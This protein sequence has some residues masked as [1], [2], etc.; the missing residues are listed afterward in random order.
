MSSKEDQTS[1]WNKPDGTLPYALYNPAP[2][3]AGKLTWMVSKDEQGRVTS[4]YRFEEI[5]NGKVVDVKREVGYLKD[6]EEAKHF[7]TELKAAGWLPLKAPTINFI[8]P[9]ETEPRDLNRKERRAVVK[10]FSKKKK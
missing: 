6:E 5:E 10:Q 4:V 7:V 8:M 1:M 9:G 3:L 2:E